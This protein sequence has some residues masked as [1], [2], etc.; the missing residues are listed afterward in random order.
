MNYDRFLE[1]AQKYKADQANNEVKFLELLV[2]Q[3]E[4]VLNWKKP[5][6]SYASWAE[7]LREEGLCTW[8]TYRNYKKARQLLSS[9]W[10]EKLGVYASISISKL[11]ETTRKTVF[12]QVKKWYGQHKVTPTYQRVSKYVRDLGGARR[13]T[14]KESKIRLMRTYIVKCQALLKK[15]K[16]EVPPE[17]WGSMTA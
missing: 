14:A 1:L 2:A 16:I 9:G 3:E 4:D 11:D 17:T 5:R 6:T 12:D 8:T 15:H 7:L 10:I 13:R